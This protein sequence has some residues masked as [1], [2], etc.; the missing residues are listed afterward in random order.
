LRDLALPVQARKLEKHL[1]RML[2]TVP[3]HVAFS[4]AGTFGQTKD[5]LPYIGSTAEFP[6]GIFALGYSGN[7]ITF[8]VIAARIIRDLAS[9]T[10][11]GDAAIFRPDR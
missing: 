4:W 10:P 5:G 11:N 9:G 2:P 3:T 1:Q 8:G 6:H 7:G